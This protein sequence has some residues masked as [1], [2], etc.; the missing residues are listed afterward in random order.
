MLA[1]RIFHKICLNRTQE[2]VKVDQGGT[3]QTP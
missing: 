1:E 2:N 3:M